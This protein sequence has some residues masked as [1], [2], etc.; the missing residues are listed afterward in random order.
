MKKIYA[1]A[2]TLAIL[3]LCAGHITAQISQGGSPTSFSMPTLTKNIDNQIVAA[4]DMEPVL[5]EDMENTEKGKAFRAGILLPVHFNPS[6]SGTWETLPN[7]DLLWRLQIT[8]DGTLGMAL[9]YDDFFLPTGAKLFLYS[10]DRSE[11]IGAFTEFNNHD[12]RLM[13]TQVIT[14]TSTIVELYLPQDQANNYALNINEVAYIY[15]DAGLMQ[16]RPADYCLI[17][18]NCPEGANWQTQKKGCA[19]ISIKIGTSYFLCSG[20]LVNNTLNSCEP[21]FLLADHCAYYNSYATA[22]NMNQWVFYFNNESSTCGG[23][24]GTTTQTVTGC[25]LKAHDTYGSGGSGSDFYLVLINSSVPSTYQVYYN[26][27]SKS[28]TAATSGVSIHHPQGDIKKIS[29]FTT[30][31]SNYST[32]WGVKWAQTVTNNYTSVTE[33]GSSGSPIFNQEKLLVGTLT[34]GGSYCSTPEDM[35]YYGKF[36]RHWDQNGTTSDKQLKPWLDPINSNPTTKTGV[37]YN[38]CSGAAIEEPVGPNLNISLYPNPAVDVI[39]LTF[40][41]YYFEKG[42]VRVIDMLG[43]CILEQNIDSYVSEISVPL[44]NLPDGIYFISAYDSNNTFSQS[45]MI[46]R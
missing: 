23:T 18:V 8:L 24:T 33:P 36:Q 28:T 26:G 19:K 16:T 38:A 17:N 4:P 35:D 10:P 22:A 39:Y 14:G 46:S 41:N 30:T 21:Y 40:E 25:A 15:R 34:G 20:S 37:N 44:K 13:A 2:V 29:T 45:F 43:N 3:F 42:V 32:H 31:L 1:F 11:I 12:S 5:M 7:G 27:W 9:Y 6:N